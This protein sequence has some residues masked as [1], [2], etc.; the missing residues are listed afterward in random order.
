MQRSNN[1]AAN[2]VRFFLSELKNSSNTS[3][4]KAIQRFQGYLER[5]QP[6]VIM[7]VLAPEFEDCSSSVLL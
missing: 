4:L 7:S 6:E 2:Q 1:Y 5:F 3:K